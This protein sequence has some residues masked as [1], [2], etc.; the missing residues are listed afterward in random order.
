LIIV[1]AKLTPKE[2]VASKII[3]EAQALIKATREEEGCIG[4]NLYNPTDGDKTLL[5][6]EQWEEKDHLKSH[7]QQTH[8]LDFESAIGDLAESLE[9][10]VYSSEEIEL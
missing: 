10:K 4:Y 7:L 2:N 6:V 9:I 3:D 5:F 8:F 1:L